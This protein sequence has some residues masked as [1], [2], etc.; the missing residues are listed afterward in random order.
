M[1]NPRIPATINGK[2]CVLAFDMAAMATLKEKYGIGLPELANLQ[3][4]I[5]EQSA[6][7]LLMKLLYAMTRSMDDPPTEKDIQRMSPGEVF[8]IRNGIELA[9]QSTM[10]LVEGEKSG[11]AEKPAR[12]RKSRGTGTRRLSRRSTSSD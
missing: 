2:P 9:M 11:V 3:K 12:A 4:E 8:A 6:S 10:R 7:S 5:P 1:I